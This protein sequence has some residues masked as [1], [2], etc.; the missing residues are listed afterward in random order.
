MSIT[1]YPHTGNTNIG[2]T[3]TRVQLHYSQNQ[4][5]TANQHLSGHTSPDMCGY[6]NQTCLSRFLAAKG[7]LVLVSLL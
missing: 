1:T 3:P 2:I 5:N 7:L 4:H 6:F